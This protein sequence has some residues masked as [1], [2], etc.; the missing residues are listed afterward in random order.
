LDALLSFWAKLGDATW[1]DKY[2]PVLCHLNVVGEKHDGFAVDHASDAHRVFAGCQRREK[3]RGNDV[4]SAPRRSI[5]QW[6]CPHAGH[7]AVV[8]DRDFV[9]HLHD[10]SR[11]TEEVKNLATEVLGIR[12]LVRDVRGEP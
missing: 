12:F 2:H 6:I 3:G 8:Q 5:Q 10:E 7:I 11:D 9:V 1:P 4:I